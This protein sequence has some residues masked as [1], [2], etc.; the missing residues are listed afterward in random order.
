MGHGEWSSK[1]ILVYDEKS[2]YGNIYIYILL[3]YLCN[4]QIAT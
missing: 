4:A 1:N 2:N 3:I